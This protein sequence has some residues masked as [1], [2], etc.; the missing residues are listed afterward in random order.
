M[1]RNTIKYW[2]PIFILLSA[3]C[4]KIIEFKGGE[5]EPKL[6]FYSN[7]EKDSLISCQI[8]V[9]H[10]V[11]DPEFQPFQI[12]NAVVS[13]YKDDV[14]LEDL[15][16]SDPIVSEYDNA[17]TYPLSTYSSGTIYAEAGT[18]YRIEVSVPGF[19]KIQSEARLPELVPIIQLDTVM[20]TTREYD[21]E[22]VTLR[23]K[24]K[25]QDPANIANFYRLVIFEQTGYYPGNR[26]YPFDPEIPVLV[27]INNINWIESSDPLLVPPE[28]ED[29]FGSYEGN[30]FLIFSD[31]KIGGREYELSFNLNSN[32]PYVDTSY[33]EFSNY[34]IYL[35][36]ITE[37]TYY[38][39]SSLTKYHNHE[40]DF[41]TEPVI[42]YSNV[43]NGL[44]VFTA[45]SYSSR[46]LTY[47]RYPVPGVTYEDPD[48]YWGEK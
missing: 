12:K 6:V 24:L 29:I 21:W 45:S 25:F 47:G 18:D 37:E 1:Y 7:L 39:L 40:N 2:L 23:V 13:L 34:Y 30:E 8:G 33:H 10:A 38:Y 42:L 11:F 20:L 4:E 32:N 46:T 28:E 43:E 26:G 16:Y 22:Y 19:D 5:T 44:G 14:F 3:G 35:Q 27:S 17:N 15:G 48:D 41:L 9:S 31:E 36:S